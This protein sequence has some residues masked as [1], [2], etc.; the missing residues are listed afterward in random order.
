VAG[1]LLQADELHV[2]ALAVAAL[3]SDEP[4][5]RAALRQ[6]LGA[7]LVAL[8]HPLPSGVRRRA[9]RALADLMRDSS[10][11][12]QILNRAI[13]NWARSALTRGADAEVLALLAESLAR[14]PTLRQSGETSVVFRRAAPVS[15]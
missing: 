3:T 8:E 7:L 14:D 13:L 10:T 6:H 11:A 15:N 1:S 5:A 9:I 12:P 2:R 4:A